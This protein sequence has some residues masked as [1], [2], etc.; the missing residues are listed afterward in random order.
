MYIICSKDPKHKQVSLPSH[1]SFYTSIGPQ[2]DTKTEAGMRCIQLRRRL[3][4]S[5]GRRTFLGREYRAARFV[6]MD[7]ILPLLLCVSCMLEP[8]VVRSVVAWLCLLANLY[9]GRFS[10]WRM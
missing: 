6:S 5:V 7:A 8:L 2:A 3:G 1:T 10:T 9:A 4:R